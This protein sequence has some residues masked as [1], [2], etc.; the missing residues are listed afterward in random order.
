MLVQS[1]SYSQEMNPGHL[2]V[3][4]QQKGK[5]VELERFA[6]Y[7]ALEHSPS[8]SSVVKVGLLS[9]DGQ[10]SLCI[11]RV[12]MKILLGN[13]DSCHLRITVSVNLSRGFFLDLKS[14]YRYLALNLLNST[15]K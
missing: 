13:F 4:I 2:Q 6:L 15:C 8:F 10:K 12:L 11:Y 5:L 7:A 14:Y 3:V 9:T 1:L